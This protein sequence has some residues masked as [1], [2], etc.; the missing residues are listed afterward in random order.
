MATTQTR[1]GR[2]VI[3]GLGAIGMVAAYGVVQG[4]GHQLRF[5]HI[6]MNERVRNLE[7]TVQAMNVIVV[8]NHDLLIEIAARTSHE[9]SP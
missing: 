3:W 1:N 8:E 7:L 5:G 9:T 2:F 4:V 6:G